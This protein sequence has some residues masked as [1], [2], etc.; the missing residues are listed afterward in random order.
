MQWTRRDQKHYSSQHLHKAEKDRLK[1]QLHR[2]P[3]V[4]G[5]V[6]RGKEQNRYAQL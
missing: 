4:P 3:D 1:E 2:N 6:S 5:Q